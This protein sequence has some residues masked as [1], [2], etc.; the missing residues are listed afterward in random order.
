MG[1]IRQSLRTRR[2]ALGAVV[3]IVVLAGV[4]FLLAH[5]TVTPANFGRLRI[6]LSQ[7][8]VHELL[9]PPRG[10]WNDV[11]NVTGPDQY[12][13]NCTQDKESLLA[14]GYQ[15]YLREQWSSPEITIIAVFDQDRR[16]VCRYRRPGQESSWLAAHS[17]P[18]LRDAQSR[19]TGDA[20]RSMKPAQV[21]ESR[22]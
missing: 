3:A 22:I 5:E 6:G 1:A 21:R 2:T 18:F 15:E 17:P 9:G 13:T 20:I 4:F 7:A 11:G 19:S 8:E 12:A 10:R 14:K 16:L